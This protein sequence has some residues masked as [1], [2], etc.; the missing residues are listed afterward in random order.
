LSSCL[1]SRNVKVK[2][3]KTIILPA[4]LHGCDTWSLTVREERR[5]RVFEN[6][7]LRRIIGPKSDNVAGEWR[8]L[9][10]EELHTSYSSPNVIRQMKLRRMGWAGHVACGMWH[11]WERRE[12]CTTLWWESP[13]ERDHL[14]DQA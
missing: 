8:N 9:H 6:R 13:K 1:L 12:K 14:E 11:A 4:V 3:H 2:V 7:V 5:L 10:S